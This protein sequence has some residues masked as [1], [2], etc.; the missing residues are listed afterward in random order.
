MWRG[1]FKNIEKAA[2]AFQSIGVKKG[3]VVTIMSMHTPEVI[4]CIYALNRLGAVANMVYL[5]LSEQEI[6]KT[7]KN[8]ESKAL[9]V[10][11]IALEKINNIR[12]ELELTNVIVISPS[13][14][15]KRK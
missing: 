13:D 7:V 9:V 6:V 11:N 14:S 10:L 1:G 5:T 2:K 4:Y 8:T 15:M 3:D 12:D